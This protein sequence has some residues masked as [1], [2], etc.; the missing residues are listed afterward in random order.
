MNP[1]RISAIA[2]PPYAGRGVVRERGQRAAM[3]HDTLDR[4][5]GE[6]LAFVRLEMVDALLKQPA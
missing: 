3:K 4:G 2:A 1:L 5:P 6:H